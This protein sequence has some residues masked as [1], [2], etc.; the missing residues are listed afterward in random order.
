MF[1]CTLCSQPLSQVCSKHAY[2]SNGFLGLLNEPV[3]D[4]EVYAECKSSSDDSDSSNKIHML[5]KAESN[6]QK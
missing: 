2:T 5:D 1:S 4:L 6:Y 3:S